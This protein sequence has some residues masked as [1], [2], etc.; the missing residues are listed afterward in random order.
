M[1]FPLKLDVTLTVAVREAFYEE[2]CLD[3][4]AA[5]VELVLSV[6]SHRNYRQ[7]AYMYKN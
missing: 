3:L 7:S 6:V 5:T 4:W 1:L 2:D